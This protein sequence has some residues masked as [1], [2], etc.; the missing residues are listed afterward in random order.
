VS[1]RQ[2]AE[3]LPYIT[4]LRKVP[5]KFVE[6]ADAEIPTT[7][8]I[9]NCSNNPETYNQSVEFKKKSDFYKALK[10]KLHPQVNVSVNYEEAG[11]TKVVSGIDSQ[12]Q[13]TLEF[14]GK[15][16]LSRQ[17]LKDRLMKS[18]PQFQ[19]LS[20]IKTILKTFQQFIEQNKT[21]VQSILKQQQFSSPWQVLQELLGD[22]R[23]KFS[24]FSMIENQLGETTK[25][26]LLE[27]WEKENG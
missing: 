2:E 12:S 20:N 13:M 6:W 3:N 22:E 11:V 1:E 5:V 17:G 15:D 25:T 21:R 16:I 18:D 23:L 8:L 14:Q 27:K 7:Y 24:F 10:E 19:K 26:A 4:L 9:A